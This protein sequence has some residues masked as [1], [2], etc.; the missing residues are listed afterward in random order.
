MNPV[1]EFIAVDNGEAKMPMPLD[2]ELAR[3]PLPLFGIMDPWCWFTVLLLMLLLL[4][5][6]M[7][8]EFVEE[9]DSYVFC[10][11]NEALELLLCLYKSL[12]LNDAMVVVVLLF[13]GASKKGSSWTF[14]SKIND[15]SLKAGD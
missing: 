6:F 3:E 1:G 12:L 15:L 7:T 14:L 10:L 13:D 9:T 5:L 11:Y 2:E 8:Y 4:M